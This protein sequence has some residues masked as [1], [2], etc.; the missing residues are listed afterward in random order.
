MGGQ[1]VERAHPGRRGVGEADDPARFDRDEQNVAG[2]ER[3][4]PAQLRAVD[5][6]RLEP[7]T[8]DG[9]VG[10]AVGLDVDQRHRRRFV[11]LRR[12]DHDICCE[13]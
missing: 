10:F 7:W 8:E 3:G 13:E 1:K 2:R 12:T 9:L 4:V 11:V 5:V 6:H